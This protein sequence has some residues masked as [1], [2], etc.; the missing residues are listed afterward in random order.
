MAQSLQFDK[1]SGG[2]KAAILMLAL[3]EDQAASLF[4]RL[5]LDEV[6][7]ISQTMSV[8]GRIDNVIVENVLADFNDR[9]SSSGGVVGSFDTTEKLLT[10]FLDN[11]RVEL[12]M[13]EIRGPAGRTVWDK[14]GNVNENVLAS[15]LKNEYP[16]T[17]AVV[18]SRI[19]PAH[20][21]R[22]LS[23]LPDDFAV[24]VVMRMLRMEVVQKDIL[25]DVEK[26]LRAEFMSN[27]AR[28]IRRDNHEVMAEIFNYFDR[29]TENRFIT[30]LEER[31]KESA[32]RIKALM[33]TFE[34][35]VKLDSSGIQ[36]LLRNAGNDRIGIALKGGT[37]KVKELFF[38]NMS[39]R[40]SKIL[41]EDMEAMGPVRMR[42]VEEA[43][44]FLVNMAKELAASGEIF[45]AD[46][47]EDELV[48]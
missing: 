30:T 3:N 15:Y 8:L 9:L 13:E 41:R 16:Q 46:G 11:E 28:T 22:V 45:L 25:A 7:E 12:I 20:A 26:T 31:S 5:E 19:E 35:L 36:T 4:S 40:A 39:E 17:V 48:Y 2:E 47:K 18:L 14:L 32:D 34:D 29:A 43:Q 24:E 23:S 37:D 42:D 21:A 1:L 44:Q 6:K 33:F 10:R 38:S 27:L